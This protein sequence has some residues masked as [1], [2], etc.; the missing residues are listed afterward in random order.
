MN[1]PRPSAGARSFIIAMSRPEE[2]LHGAV[3]SSLVDY[4]RIIGTTL[5]R[6]SDASANRANHAN[7]G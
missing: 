5:L 2:S 3:G 6:H 1:T 4:V 7:R